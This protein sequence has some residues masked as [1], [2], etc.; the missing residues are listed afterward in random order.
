MTGMLPPLL[1]LPRG[2]GGIGGPDRGLARLPIKLNPL[3]AAR[4]PLRPA[5]PLLAQPH[6]P[7]PPGYTANVTSIQCNPATFPFLL[8]SLDG[9]SNCQPGWAT[10]SPPSSSRRSGRSGV[11]ATA[12]NRR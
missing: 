7:F 2:L 3:L 9:L 8:P 4:P 11:A 12:A 5:P 1:T 10:K 6:L